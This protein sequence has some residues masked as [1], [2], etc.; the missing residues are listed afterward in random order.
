M[1]RPKEDYLLDSRLPYHVWVDTN[2]RNIHCNDVASSSTASMVLR[3]GIITLTP[4]P[5]VISRVQ[6]SVQL[7]YQP[8]DVFLTSPA[9]TSAH[10]H[11][12]METESQ[13]IQVATQ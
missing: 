8:T 10:Q 4:Q 13:G 11:K 9:P 5:A 3:G 6:N 12:V 7:G 1:R 2:Q